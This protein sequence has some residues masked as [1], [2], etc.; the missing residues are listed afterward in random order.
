VNGKGEGQRWRSTLFKEAWWPKNG[1]SVRCGV[2]VGAR[3]MKSRG[4]GV[5]R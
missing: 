4:G 1:G 3:W 5:T 2:G